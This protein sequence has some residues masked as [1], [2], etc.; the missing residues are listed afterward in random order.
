MSS[1]T[2]QGPYIT[3]YH[4]TD[5]RARSIAYRV[6]GHVLEL[7]RTT[8][9]DLEVALE[10]VAADQEAADRAL[11][12]TLAEWDRQHE[13]AD[14]RPPAAVASGSGRRHRGPARRRSNAAGGW[15][16]LLAEAIG[17]Q[18]NQV[19]LSWET[20]LDVRAQAML[21]ALGPPV[22]S[23]SDGRPR[24]SGIGADGVLRR[25]RSCGTSA[26]GGGVRSRIGR[27][28]VIRPALHG[29]GAELD[30]AVDGGCV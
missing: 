24:W 15:R 23:S 13:E 9:G 25:G 16:E 8:G 27:R 12:G 2:D 5:A 11:E 17:T 28:H 30:F 26:G 21:T 22:L 10:R 6:V 1:Q 4:L 18:P 14:A 19:D 7:M 20:L 3:I 29:A